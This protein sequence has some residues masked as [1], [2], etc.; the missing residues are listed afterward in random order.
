MFLAAGQENIEQSEYQIGDDVLVSYLVRPPS[1]LHA[2]WA[3]P[4]EVMKRE[5]NNLALRNLTDGTDRVVDVSRVKIFIFDGLSEPK[6]LPAADYGESEVVRIL[7]H[8]GSLQKH[9]E[10]EIRFEWT[11]GSL[12]RECVGWMR[13]MNMPEHS[14]D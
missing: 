7:R 11:A 1:K 14:L 9:S 3:G 2:R 13:L 12:G 5:E 10:I 6:A 8:L 4:Y